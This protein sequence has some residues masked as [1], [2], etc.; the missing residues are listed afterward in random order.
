[1][2]RIGGVVEGYRMIRGR[3]DV[4]GA[5]MGRRAGVVRDAR[6]VLVHT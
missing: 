3:R 4:V 5:V 6:V 1:V 2:K